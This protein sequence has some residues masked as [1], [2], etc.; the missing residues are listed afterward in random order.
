MN[1]LLHRARIVA[2]IAAVTLPVGWIW[3]SRALAQDA[4]QKQGQEL[5]ANLAAGR[6]VIA[7]VKDAILIGTVEDPIEAETRPPVPVEIESSR[8][9]IILGALDWFSPS[10]QQD[11]ARL[12][13]EL[14]HLK[15]YQ[16]TVAP[17]LAPSQGG[18][19]ASDIEATGQGLQHRLNDIAKDLHGKVDLP[20][21]EPLAELIVADYLGGYGPEVWQLTYGMKQQEERNNYWDTRVLPPAYLQFWP[22]EKGQPH[23]LVEFSYPPENAPAPLLELLRRGDPR[24]ERIRNSDPQ[25]ALV[26]TNLLEGQSTKLYAADTT[27]FLRAALAAIAAPNS[28]ETMSMIGVDKGFAWILPPPPEPVRA[29]AVQSPG[30]DASQAPQGERPADAPSLLKH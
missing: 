30:V 11:V 5:V 12:D 24:L 9:G 14:P 8:V 25:M 19:E 18:D 13:R 3:C 29:K 6:V 27:Q 16:V 2:S 4:T 15:A 28:R 23:T 26:V 17:H 22:P 21:G 20:A 10:S 7:I 1:G